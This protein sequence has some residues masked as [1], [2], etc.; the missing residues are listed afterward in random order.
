MIPNYHF[1]LCQWQFTIECKLVSIVLITWQVAISSD[2]RLKHKLK[3]IIVIGVHG[4]F[5]FPDREKKE[6]NSRL[7]LTWFECKCELHVVCLFCTYVIRPSSKVRVVLLR[8]LFFVEKTSAV[9]NYVCDVISPKVGETSTTTKKLEKKCS[10]MHSFSILY[11]M[12]G[13]QNGQVKQVSQ[14]FLLNFCK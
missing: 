14:T 3:V 13:G 9:W 10:G 12:L 1:S 6:F 4:R 5:F 8:S 11:I 7:C 2:S